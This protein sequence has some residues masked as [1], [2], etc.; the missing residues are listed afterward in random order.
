[1]AYRFDK[2]SLYDSYYEEHYLDFVLEKSRDSKYKDELGYTKTS[3]ET[4]EK[5]KK[6]KSE[7]LRGKLEEL[8]KNTISLLNSLASITEREQYVDFKIIRDD[9]NLD[10]PNDI[11]SSM[12]I[13]VREIDLLLGSANTFYNLK[14]IE[15]FLESNNAT[16]TLAEEFYFEKVF[17][18]QNKILKVLVDYGYTTRKEINKMLMNLDVEK[19]LKREYPGEK[20]YIKL[21]EEIPSILKKRLD[22]INNENLR[23]ILQASSVDIE[24]MI[25]K[26]SDNERIGSVSFYTANLKEVCKEY[27]KFINKVIQR[28]D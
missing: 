13:K 7:E 20:L 22:T 12:H 3:I 28:K 6:E 2:N 27:K 9:P 21:E 14:K 24:P 1:M 10:T 18:E 11:V 25:F 19:V 16:S 23:E 17:D 4:L 8:R 26:E 5:I 15:K